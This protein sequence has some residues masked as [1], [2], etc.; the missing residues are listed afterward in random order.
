MCKSREM[1]HLMECFLLKPFRR[2]QWLR[3]Q[4]VEFLVQPR[5]RDDRDRTLELCLSKDETE[6]R[7]EEIDIRHGKLK[8]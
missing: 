5:S 2:E 8:R 4:T 3:G 6:H 7:D 1:S